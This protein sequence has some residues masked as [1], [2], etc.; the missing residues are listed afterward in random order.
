MKRNSLPEKAFAA[1][2]GDS[3]ILLHHTDDVRDGNAHAT[4]DIDRLAL[5]LKLVEELPEEIKSSAKAHLLG[6][7]RALARFETEAG[8][9]EALIDRA[10]S[11]LTFA[12][13]MTTVQHL[14]PI[15]GPANGSARFV[16]NTKTCELFYSIEA[17]ELSTAG[18]GIGLYVGLSGTPTEEAELLA[19]LPNGR[20]V[21]GSVQ[22][23][24]EQCELLVKGSV[25]V[26]V[27]TS[28]YPM[29]E[30]R[31][32]V[33]PTFPDDRVNA[34]EFSGKPRVG[35]GNPTQTRKAEEKG[36]YSEEAEA[37][38]EDM[39]PKSDTSAKPAAEP[40]TKAGQED[41]TPTHLTDERPQKEPGQGGGSA[42]G[43]TKPEDGQ[44]EDK[45]KSDVAAKP[46]A[47]PGSVEASQEDESSE[48]AT[49]ASILD[50][51]SKA[52]SA[53]GNRFRRRSVEKEQD[54]LG[55]PSPSDL[56]NK[57]LASNVQLDGQSGGNLLVESNLTDPNNSVLKMELEL[58][59]TPE[60][61]KS[62]AT[63]TA[64][65]QEDRD[66]VILTASFTKV[67]DRVVK[68]DGDFVDPRVEKADQLIPVEANSLFEN[69][70][71]LGMKAKI[72]ETK[73]LGSTETIALMME[74]DGEEGFSYG[75]WMD[76]IRDG[77]G[78][79][80]SVKMLDTYIPAEFMKD[81][82]GFLSQLS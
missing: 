74:P 9:L 40:K 58:L 34:G 45:P 27:K 18:T 28:E 75:L 23:T 64:E 46:A 31:G 41:L 25:Q 8:A 65:Q 16:L 13:K 79:L 39:K 7:V 24:E 11:M 43:D 48:D 17:K 10:Q 44:E 33:L 21:E 50:S 76:V 51:V 19:E 38:Q 26:N 60:K 14:P 54:R 55:K 2:V 80:G 32:Q 66:S 3:R 30:I 6:H 20:I 72:I 47:E 68:M 52:T 57:V 78:S 81:F 1:I 62:F 15:F 67:G 63:P 29:G 42:P 37:G 35:S 56:A 59:D 53:I 36:E 12:A 49:F 70:K 73:K 69:G 82:A 71:F 22:L 4:V 5:C 61:I 77:E